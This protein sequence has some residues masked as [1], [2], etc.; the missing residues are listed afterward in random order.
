MRRARLRL[1]ALV[2]AAAC[3]IA[4]LQPTGS[5]VAATATVTRIGGA[6]RYATSA[7]ASAQTFSPGVAVAYVASGADFPDALAGAAAA[8]RQGGPIL[9]S[10]RDTIPAPIAQELTRLRPAR[11]VVLGGEGVVSRSVATHL[12]A[13]TTGS[14]TRIAG[15]DRF[16]TAAA[17]SAATYAPGTPVAY[18]ASGR[19][20]PDSLSGASVAGGQGG[21]LLIT[22]PV[23][24]PAAI[25][26]ELSRL[27]P[28]RIIVLGGTGAVS[29]AVATQAGAAAGATVERRAGASRYDTSAAIARAYGTGVSTVYIAS[30][31]AF[32]DALSGAAAT[33]GAPLLLTS[34]GTLP[35]VIAQELIRLRPARIVILG[36][37]GAVSPAVAGQLAFAGTDLPAATGGRLTRETE[38]RAG[39]CVN[40]PDASHRLCVG[41]DGGFGVYRGGTALWT[42]GTT[43][44]APRSLRIGPDGNVRL[45]ALDGGVLW[46]SSTA[47][48][49]ATELAVQND[50]DLMLRTATGSIVWSSM[51]SA[52]APRWRLPFGAGQR[53]AAGAP[54]ANSGGTAGARGALDFG[55]T[56]GGD[57]RVLS[58]ADGTVYRVQCGTSSYLGVNHAN[59]WQ[60]TYYH[61]VNYQEQL[62]G[63]FVPAGTYLG[64][65]GR[66]VPCGGGATF[67]HVHLVIRR[68]GN[69][70]SVEGMRFGGYTVRSDGRDY[71]GFWTDATGR[72]VLTAPGG[73]ACCLAAE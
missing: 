35:A 50:G 3:V 34:P 67:D 45:Y 46:Q 60:S 15:A 11:I 44:A 29:A 37:E 12:A 63:Q 54:H 30:G 68:A 28:S 13:Y 55:P 23:A 59:G 49:T 17:I 38:V 2:L 24:L 10:D 70:V 56:V 65:V 22:D 72:R 19:D 62:V 27:K 25:A 43:G 73:A 1:S 21:P 48:T 16:E 52:T 6:D 64:D 40:S 14:V 31:N 8:V 61:L 20:F 36:G 57:R 71:W 69:P 47:G 7:L 5:A 66:T 58:I 53:W 51:S 39:T 26:H 41:T 4:I 42:S 33:R 9:L 32:P 18:L